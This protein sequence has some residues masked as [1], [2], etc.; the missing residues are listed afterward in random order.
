[1]FSLPTSNLRPGYEYGRQPGCNRTRH[2]PQPT[3]ATRNERAVLEVP[4]ELHMPLGLLNPDSSTKTRR[5]NP[6][7]LSSS[8]R[9]ASPVI[10]IE[11]AIFCLLPATPVGSTVFMI[12]PE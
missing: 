10:G 2:A 11:P 4:T 5:S 6:T 8:Q 7:E 3:L 9:L 12:L 1:M